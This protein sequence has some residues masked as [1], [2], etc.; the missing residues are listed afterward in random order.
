MTR[1][2]KDTETGDQTPQSKVLGRAEWIAA[3]QQTLA[4][5]DAVSIA[6]AA[7]ILEATKGS[8]YWHFKSL[9]DFVEA[10]SN[11]FV[12]DAEARLEDPDP[13]A[14]AP[15]ARLLQRI[16]QDAQA[17]AAL[18]PLAEGRPGVAAAL[19]R[20]DRRRIDALAALIEAG[21]PQGADEVRRPHVIYAAWLGAP[22][23]AATLGVPAERLRNAAAR[24]L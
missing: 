22:A 12:T 13:R 24:L 11:A 5:G 3:G 19:A 20:L 18:R 14:E 16:G 17:E 21:A 10:V 23:L 2:S 7:R 6:A 15:G 1:K 9:D 8:F 4:L